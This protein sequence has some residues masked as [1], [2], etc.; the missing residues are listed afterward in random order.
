MVSP[1]I[2]YYLISSLHGLQKGEKL[3]NWW[4]KLI[5]SKSGVDKFIALCEVNCACIISMIIDA[6]AA[7]FA[8]KLLK[9]YTQTNRFNKYF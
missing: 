2:L 1:F 8:V 4:Y 5:V 7:V 6:P 3:E 9:L